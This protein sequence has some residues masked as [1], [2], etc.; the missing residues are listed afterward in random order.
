MN[1]RSESPVRLPH[2]SV[3]HKKPRPL[4]LAFR[5]T[6]RGSNVTVRPHGEEEWAIPIDAT[7][8]LE[9]TTRLLAVLEPGSHNES[10]LGAIVRDLSNHLIH[11][12][13]SAIDSCTELIIDLPPPTLCI[14][15]DLLTYRRSPLCLKR[16]TSY[17]VSKTS[18]EPFSLQASRTALILSDI[19]ADP[20]RA[21]LAVASILGR[22][23]YQ[24]SREVVLEHLRLVA[25][26]DI[27]LFS[28]HGH[29]GGGMPD[30]MVVSGGEMHPEDLAGLKPRLVYFDSCR[31]GVSY[32]FIKSFCS[33]GTTYYVAPVIS[34][35]AGTS[36][37]QTMIKFFENLLAGNSVE[38]ALFLTRREL[39]RLYR[40]CDV[41][42]RWWRALAFRVYRLN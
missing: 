30:K 25:N 28:L 1:V 36:S 13:E 4:H 8:L 29:V 22:V 11:P 7:S 12:I 40:E 31:L 32:D 41:C 21:C 33:L 24:D 2:I 39:W 10:E 16:P 20:E 34:N 26:K 38:V 19:G 35:E 18:E 14:P 9:Q 37:T 3:L 6:R 17:R 23:T 5:I 15:I 42:T 27:V